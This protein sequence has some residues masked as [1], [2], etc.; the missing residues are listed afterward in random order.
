MRFLPLALGFFVLSAGCAY[1]T[2]PV[3]APDALPIEVAEVTASDPAA[4]EE[5]RHDTESILARAT[6]GRAGEP[7]RVRVHVMLEDE[8]NWV[9]AA[10][11][12]DGMALFGAWPVLFGMTTARQ[13]VS[14]DVTVEMRGCTLWGHGSARREGGIYAPARRRALAVALDRALADAFDVQNT[15]AAEGG[16]ELRDV[17]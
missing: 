14:V 11:R 5:L 13:D 4:A 6:K 2:P 12:K 16:G 7:A 3:H 15:N 17:K 8:Y 1:R 9:D 10:M